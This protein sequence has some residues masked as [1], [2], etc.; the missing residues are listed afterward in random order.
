MYDAIL[1]D[2]AQDF[3]LSFMRLCYEILYAPKRLVYA[4]DE[5]Q[6]LNLESLP[7][8][9]VLFGID[10]NGSPNVQFEF[11]PDGTSKQDIILEKCYRN[12]RQHLYLHMLW[13]LES[14]EN[15][16]LRQMYD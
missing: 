15:R 9:E 5:L 14:I 11:E 2:E 8:P 12:S 13:V 16:M 1:I 4:Y 10:E 6:N 3:P 7:S